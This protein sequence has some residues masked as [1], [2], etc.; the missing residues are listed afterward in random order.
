MSEKSQIIFM[1]TR[2]IRLASEKWHLS[3]DRIIELFKKVDVFGYI[4]VGYGI[5]HCEGDEAV[6]EDI[7]ELLKRK[8][9]KV[10]A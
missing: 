8:G 1:Q 6:L 2:I 9:I 5:F 7:S 4:E 10:D 3:I